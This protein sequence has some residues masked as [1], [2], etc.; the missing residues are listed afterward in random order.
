MHAH[1]STHIMVVVEPKRH[2]DRSVTIAPQ[3]EPQ[4][5]PIPNPGANEPMLYCPICSR[6]LAEIKCK[7]LCKQCGYYMSCADYY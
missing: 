4:A 6:R 1:S 5:P 2:Q 7:L 3:T